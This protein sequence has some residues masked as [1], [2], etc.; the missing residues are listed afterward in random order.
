MISLLIQFSPCRC[1]RQ[2]LSR[3]KITPSHPMPPRSYGAGRQRV[4]KGRRV[5]PASKPTCAVRG[6]YESRAGHRSK[7]THLC[8]RIYQDCPCGTDGNSRSPQSGP[9]NL[10]RNDPRFCRATPVFLLASDILRG[11]RDQ[12]AV[13]QQR[14]RLVIDRRL[15]C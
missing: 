5:F 2:V 14:V 15:L 11:L 3:R 6:S 10:D 8:D 13:A 12:A 7:F 9:G 1:R 4:W